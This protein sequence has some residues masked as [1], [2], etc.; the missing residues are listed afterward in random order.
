MAQMNLPTNQKQA[1]RHRQ[2]SC[3]CQGGARG[4]GIDWEFGVSDANY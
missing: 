2:L 1:N 4:S 3:G